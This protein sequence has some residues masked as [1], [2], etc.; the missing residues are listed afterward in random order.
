MNRPTSD[1]PDRLL[2][3]DATDFERRVLKAA[4]DRKPSPAASARMAKALGVTVA[5]ATTTA[6]A[7]ALAASA[8][9]TKTSAVAGTSTLWPWVSAG[10]LG[11]AVAGAVVGAR[12]RHVPA[13]PVAPEA[14]A[15]PAA[16]APKVAGPAQSAPVM[17]EVAAS[18]APSR[19][20]GAPVARDLGDQI[21]F[22]D[23][24][25][26]ALSV[27]ADRRALDLLRDYQDRYPSGS[28]R[29]EATALRVEALVK[30]GRQAEARSLAERFVVEHR[31]T[32]LAA[33]VAELAG[34]T[35][36]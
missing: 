34:L 32:L 2:A 14:V 19:R 33:R 35:A 12:A 30:L 28:F 8:A 22:I 10:V 6:A 5:V 11:L 18:P 17:E 13:R 16:V 9:V 7:K 29:P 20:R 36:R 4:L 3:A 26:A 21:E 1:G 24:V 15:V 23:A 31:G 25:R 27:G